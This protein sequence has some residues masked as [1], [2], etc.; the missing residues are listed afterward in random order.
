M[1]EQRTHGGGEKILG[2]LSTIAKTDKMKYSFHER[3]ITE[4]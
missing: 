2:I 3:D 1:E 4:V